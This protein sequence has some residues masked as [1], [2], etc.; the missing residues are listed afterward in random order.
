MGTMQKRDTGLELWEHLG[1]AET[2]NFKEVVDA[3]VNGA[4]FEAHKKNICRLSGSRRRWLKQAVERS[5]S[6][7]NI[8]STSS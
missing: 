7:E 4:I 2:A 5:S 3:K 6:T 1:Q 8:V